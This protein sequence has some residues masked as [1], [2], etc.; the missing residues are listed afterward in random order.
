MARSCARNYVLVIGI[1][2][3]K[4]PARSTA[5]VAIRERRRVRPH[6]GTAVSTQPEHTRVP[7]GLITVSSGRW[8]ALSLLRWLQLIDPRRSLSSSGQC[9]PKF[10]IVQRNSSAT[11][12]R[13]AST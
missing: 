13:V 11:S 2:N 8:S 6:I 1:M 4:K 12:S 5:S 9:V 10:L 7:S 3:C